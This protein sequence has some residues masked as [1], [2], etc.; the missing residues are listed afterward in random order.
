MDLDFGIL[1]EFPRTKLGAS[2]ARWNYGNL[3]V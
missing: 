1:R 2:H 3:L